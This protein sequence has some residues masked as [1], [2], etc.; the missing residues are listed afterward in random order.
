MRNHLAQFHHNLNGDIAKLSIRAEATAKP[1]VFNKQ[2]DAQMKDPAWLGQ[3]VGD[4]A[5][6]VAVLSVVQKGSTLHVV[7]PGQPTYELV[8]ELGGR[9]HFDSVPDV[10]VQFD[11]STKN[12]LV[13]QPAST[14]EAKKL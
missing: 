3:W 13:M 2:V 8:P 1:I 7:V 14:I 6:P 10:V 11:A 4:Y 12:M 5:T 9:F